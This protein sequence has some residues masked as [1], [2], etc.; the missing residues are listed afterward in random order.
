MLK[1]DVPEGESG[2]WKVERFEV[3]NNDS[4][5]SM[6]SYGARCVRPGSYTKL[7]RNGRVIMSDTSAEIIDHYWLKEQKGTGLVNGLG[8]GVGLEL[9]MENASF[10]YVV[11]NSKNVL[12]LVAEHY[13]FKYGDRLEIIFA[14]ALSYRPPKWMRLDFVWHDIWDNISLDNLPEMTLLKRRYGRLCQGNQ[15]CWSQDLL[16]HSR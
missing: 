9:C 2:S 11:E 13:L 14:D 1:L 8:L 16:R 5:A 3:T 7:T 6:F 10:V 12:S 4:F 15:S